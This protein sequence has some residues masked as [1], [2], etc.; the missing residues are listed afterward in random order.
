MPDLTHPLNGNTYNEAFLTEAFRLAAQSMQANQGG[1]FGAVVVIDDKIIGTG[2][3]QV[4]S[5]NDPT[6]HAE[7]MAIRDACKKLNRFDLRGAVIYSTCEPCP[8]CFSAI[9]WAGIQRVFYASTREDAA[10]I[11]FK[12][13]WIY[14]EIGKEPTG[15]TVNFQRVIHPAAPRL[16][17]DWDAKQ[18]K[19]SY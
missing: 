8:M 4:T 17:S 7:I 15:R 3:N 19:I 10:A 6:A 11:G 13:S 14:D 16:F 1:P 12:D 18:D 9:Y 5:K 2:V